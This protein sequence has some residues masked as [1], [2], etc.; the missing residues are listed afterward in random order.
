MRI[1]KEAGG[2]GF[3]LREL[4]A[5]AGIHAVHHDTGCE[6]PGKT[7][8]RAADQVVADGIR[9]GNAGRTSC[10]PSAL[11]DVGGCQGGRLVGAADVEE[12]YVLFWE[13]RVRVCFSGV[14]M[15][16]AGRERREDVQSRWF[17]RQR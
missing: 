1:G 11:V 15:R 6:R 2:V 3:D 8:N 4:E 12:G 13:R 9:E 7:P 16:M 14:K 10:A 17:P 5:S